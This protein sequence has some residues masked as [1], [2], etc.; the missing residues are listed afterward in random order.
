VGHRWVMA[1]R[2]IRDDGMTTELIR[3]RLIQRSRGQLS[4]GREQGGMS[5]SLQE[6]TKSTRAK[7]IVDKGKV[8]VGS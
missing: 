7:T 2:D 3:M 5:S 4:M 8:V 1:A 6:T